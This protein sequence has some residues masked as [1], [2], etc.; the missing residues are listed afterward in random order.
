ME[1]ILPFGVKDKTQYMMSHYGVSTVQEYVQR[2]KDKILSEY[3]IILRDTINDWKPYMQ[4]FNNLWETVPQIKTMEHLARNKY[5]Q[6]IQK[7][8]SFLYTVYNVRPSPIIQKMQGHTLEDKIISY[9]QY[10]K[11][12]EYSVIDGDIYDAIASEIYKGISHVFIG[13]REIR[14]QRQKVIYDML[15]C[16][17]G[18]ELKT[19][20]ISS[21]I[22][23]EIEKL[24]KNIN[25]L[26]EL[27]GV[28]TAGTIMHPLIQKNL[29]HF[30]M[31]DNPFTSSEEP[32]S[33]K[34]ALNKLSL[35]EHPLYPR[36]L[37]FF[38]KHDIEY[39]NSRIGSLIETSFDNICTLSIDSQ[40]FIRI[41][42]N[43][44]ELLRRHIKISSLISII[45]QM[46]TPPKTVNVRSNVIELHFP[47][48]EAPIDNKIFLSKKLYEIKAEYVNGIK[49]IDNAEV[50]P[51]D[52]SGSISSNKS[53][54]VKGLYVLQLD[55]FFMKRYGLNDSIVS[56]F[57]KEKIK[58][59][60]GIS[61]LI[62]ITEDKMEIKGIPE[63]K[64][65]IL[66]VIKEPIFYS[67]SEIHD[68]LTIHD[69]EITYPD[70]LIW[71]ADAV[72]KKIK[73]ITKDGLNKLKV[74][75]E[76]LYVLKDALNIKIISGNVAL[77]LINGKLTLD[78]VND[79]QYEE[80]I[81]GIRKVNQ[82]IS[83]RSMRWYIITRGIGAYRDVL[84]L[85]DIDKR[86][87]ICNNPILIYEIYGI[88]ALESWLVEVLGQQVG[89]YTG[90]TY[91][92]YI[93]LIC[94]NI[95][96]MGSPIG[97]GHG[98]LFD[99]DKMTG[100]SSSLFHERTF[101][102]MSSWA[103][104]GRIVSDDTLYAKNVFYQ[105]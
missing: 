33:L 18:K 22:D 76:F 100:E 61:P 4:D 68:M 90:D 30:V 96:S 39:V 9:L 17:R 77:R 24:I 28:F 88:E 65:S 7:I 35:S 95:T 49:G 12:N 55:R 74:N 91:T 69:N 80:L 46:E 83:R 93:N 11:E 34:N 19:S 101:T 94:K 92:E 64:G 81:N 37:I 6:F 50:V 103:G 1:D 52:I 29:K 75:D 21:F 82:E 63:F 36:N 85:P 54:F 102:T 70:D 3:E 23:M 105:N 84:K 99:Y 59:K 44:E 40:M 42:L 56:E 47:Q 66:S 67:L 97:I 78:K 57:I 98:G 26:P 51:Y 89:I 38:K 32:L 45:D 20:K 71:W 72:S 5:D 13:T 2:V 53:L 58:E 43:M 8:R 62:T 31:N 104:I 15:E 60:L 48:K 41:T 16:C 25:S 10:I 14:E 87:T 27:I 79:P 73:G 86:I